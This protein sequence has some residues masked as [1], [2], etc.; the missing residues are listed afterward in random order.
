[1]KQ[2]RDLQ[3]FIKSQPTDITEFDETLVNRL[4][5]KVTVFE[6]KF[7]VEFKSGVALKIER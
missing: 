2:I 1:M 3:D 5:E 7:I 6:D 4:I